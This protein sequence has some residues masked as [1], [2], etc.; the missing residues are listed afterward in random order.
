MA[1][2]KSRPELSAILTQGLLRLTHIS[3]VQLRSELQAKLTAQS[4]TAHDANVFTLEEGDWQHK[5]NET[6]R[7]NT[8]ND[9]KRV[10]STFQ[11][12]FGI[13]GG[14]VDTV[15]KELQAAVWTHLDPGQG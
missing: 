8:R 9:V 7:N 15:T 5:S 2:L 6:N 10:L 4:C 3:T 12:P 1:L 14:G 11:G 13:L